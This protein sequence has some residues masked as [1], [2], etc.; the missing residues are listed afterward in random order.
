MDPIIQERVLAFSLANKEAEWVASTNTQKSK[1][2][3]GTWVEV[4]NSSN[5]N[6]D[7]DCE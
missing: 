7:I 2:F 1:T 5:I 6:Q 4:S 3:F